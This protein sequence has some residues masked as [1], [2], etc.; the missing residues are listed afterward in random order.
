MGLSGSR[1]QDR[2]PSFDPPENVLV[3]APE[4]VGDTADEACGALLMGDS[5]TE[6]TIVLVCIG[7]SPADRLAVLGRDDV[8]PPAAVTV[9]STDEGMGSIETSE[10]ESV[11]AVESDTTVRTTVVSG[12]GGI[13]GISHKLA[14]VLSEWD[15]DVQGRLCFYSVTGLLAHADLSDAFRFLHLLTR[16]VSE[17]GGIAHFHMDSTA[18]DAETVGTLDGLFDTVM[19]YEDGNWTVR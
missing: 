16:H 14:D 18:H 3:L 8:D 5:P 4:G 12:P 6:E 7:E 17:V 10:D 9:I 15:E 1:E 11:D 13:T 2:W 19:E